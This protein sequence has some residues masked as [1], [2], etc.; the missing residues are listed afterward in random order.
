MRASRTHVVLTLQVFVLS[1]IP[2]SEGGAKPRRPVPGAARKAAETGT[3]RI[4]CPVEGARFLVDEGRETSVEG[5]T[6]S[7]D[8]VLPVGSHTIRVSK[9]GYLPFSEVFDITA[10]EVTELEVDLVLYSG[11]LQVEAGP[12]PVQVQVDERDVGTAPIEMDLAI[13]EHV[14]RM[15][16]PGYVEEVRRPLVRTGQTTRVEVTLVP[17]EVAARKATGGPVY[18][19]WWFWGVV[20]AVV[21]GAVVPT[22][23]LTRPKSRQAETPHVIQLP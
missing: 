19:K 12:P 5:V 10:G 2:S 23:I 1:L 13:G 16:K 9:D 6:P 18:A 17:V 15:T 4:V 22:V 11:R 20:G 14:V 8:V 21:V 3:L 7:P